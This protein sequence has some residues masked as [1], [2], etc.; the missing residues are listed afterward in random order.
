V[1]AR[2]LGKR[3]CPRDNNER[4]I[5]AIKEW[6]Q[7]ST[8]KPHKPHEVERSVQHFDH[9]LS[10]IHHDAFACLSDSI[11][12]QE[13]ERC[14][15][16]NL[17]I[18]QLNQ[19]LNNRLPCHKNQQLSRGALSQEACHH[20]PIA[21]CGTSIQSAQFQIIPCSSTT[22]TQQFQHIQCLSLY[23]NCAKIFRVTN[24][25]HFQERVAAV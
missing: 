24:R 16:T 3:Q 18:F 4:A 13:Q 22:T 9:V 7:E 1:T 2:S 20:T 21:L 12:N 10:R 17:V 11:T 8:K 15:V 25:H 19:S 6:I 5:G 23:Q 14:R